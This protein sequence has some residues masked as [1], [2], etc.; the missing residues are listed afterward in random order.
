MRKAL[1]SSLLLALVVFSGCT[2]G[3]NAPAVNITGSA[4]QADQGKT[5]A[6]TA[7]VSNDTTNAGVTWAIASGPGSLSGETTSGATYNAPGTIA[8][9]TTVVVAATSIASPTVTS[10]ITITLE[11]P[12]Q[13]A[14]TVMPEGIVS[15]AYSS[16]VSMTG[17]VAPYTWSLIAAPAGITLA[18]STSSTVTVQ[19][20]PTTAGAN[21]TFTIKV[22]DADG[23][24]VTSSGLT[25]TVYPTLTITA[26]TFPT[27]V[28]GVAYTA[29]AF[30]ASGG[31]GSG[32]TF[33]VASGSLAPLTINSSS[34]V[35]SGT[36]TTSTTLHFTIKVTDSAS[37]AATTTSLSITVN[38]AITVSLSPTSPVSLDQTKTQLITATV[39]NDPNSAG[40]TW[41]LTSGLGSLSGSSTTSVTYNAPSTVSVTSSAVVTATSIT[42]SSKKATF[43]I[44]L[45][46]PPQITTSTMAAGNVNGAYSSP[47]TMTGGVAPYAWTIVTGPTGITLASS[48]SSTVTVQGTPSVSGNNQT[49]TIKVTDADGL[50]VTSSGLTITVYPTLTITAP[51]LPTGVA[52]VGYTAQAFTASGGSGSGYTFAV[53]SGSLSPLTIN[54]SSGVI[55]G[56]PTAAATLNFTIKV[57]DS[58]NNT[59]TTTGLSITINP[60][61]SVTLSP[62]QP[63]A[64]DQN[65]TQLITATVNNDPG[66]AGVTWSSLTGAGSLSGSTST[67]IT[68]NA[69]A[70][71][72]TSSIA[73][74]TATSVTDTSKSSSFSVSLEPPPSFVTSSFPDGTLGSSYSSTVTMSGGVGPYAWSFTALPTGLSLSN[75]TTN[76]VNVQGTPQSAGAGQTVTI[77]VTD[78]KGLTSTLNSTMNV[79]APSCTTNCTISGTVTGPTISGVAIALSGGPTS[80]PDATTDSSGN[81]SFTG[82]AGGTYTVTPTLAGYTF[83]P[84][85]PSVTTSSSTTTQDFTE[86]SAVTSYSITGKLIY[87]GSK[88]GRTFVRVYNDSCSGE[89]CTAAGTSLASAPS[90]SGTSYTVRGLQPGSYIVV[91]EID[92][93]DNG[94]PNASNPYGTSSTVTITSSNVSVPDITLTDPT[95]PTPVAP[96]NVTVA[97]GNKFALVQYNQNNGSALVDGNGREIATS[98]RVYYDTNSSFT[99]NTYYTINAHGTSDRFFIFHTLTNGTYYF[100]MTALVGST[101][102]AASTPVSATLAAGSGTYTVSGQVTFPGTATGPLYV[103]L[104]DSSHGVVYGQTIA[105]PTSPASYNFTGVAAGDYQ[106]FAIIDMNNNNVVDPSDI[107]NVNNNQGGPPPLTVSGNTVNDITLTSAVSTVT[108]TTNHDQLNGGSDT[109][110]LN[111]NLTWGSKRPV[112]MTMISGPNATV[113]WDMPVDQNTGNLQVDLGSTPPVVGDTYKFQMTFSDSTTQTLTAQV[114]AV[115]SS[116]VTGMSAQTTTPGSVTVPLFT[117]V[118]PSSTPS[119]YTYYVGLYNTSGSTSVNWNDYGGDNSN[120]IPSGTT[121]LLFNDDG[122]AN[123]SALP[124]GQDYKWYVGVQDANGNSSQ[125]T[126]T[127]TTPIP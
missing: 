114:T 14:T 29:P 55:S 34:G 28:A 35:I 4:S 79:V 108:V 105:S 110:G 72:S 80:K 121:S 103:G 122:S 32:Y 30:T 37:N 104:L 40:V 68:Y 83:S 48:T 58:V 94:H 98:Y 112:A 118:T 82:L 17:G 41:T 3:N 65:T 52:G 71:I 11:P 49:F 120:G 45:V 69:P 117:W 12:P 19:G 75:S 123:V 51:T 81:Y 87:A 89:G 22:T 86:T 107:T 97:P 24:S 127:Y 70:T 85:A 63:F 8:S 73:T 88:S 44:N 18:S 116:F 111:T 106:A 90:S 92:T 50:S 31:S 43:T 57:T 25:I 33:A 10:S 99:N 56:S 13:I 84:S 62:G 113:P 23:L 47:V 109:Y 9:V 54:S 91:A 21:Q 93:L 6:L 102:S 5:V 1:L 95:P 125:E 66:S 59:A 64:M 77:K 20:M 36:P 67:T 39:S 119:P 38:P 101:E 53:A 42:D 2:T 76:T 100:K 126:T 96:S 15:V 115:L 124:S 78:A 60:A 46:P 7:S 26:P 61:I 27:G 74:F 16:S